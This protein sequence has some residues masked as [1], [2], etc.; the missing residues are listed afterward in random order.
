MNKKG[1]SNLAE[2][3]LV[4]SAIIVLA[5]IIVWGTEKLGPFGYDVVVMECHEKVYK[6]ECG[7]EKCLYTN[8][9]SYH[10]GI[11]HA[12]ETNYLRC[13]LGEK[14]WVTHE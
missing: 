1:L 3:I 9:Y 2:T 5:L 11:R 12:A 10:D 7:L 4:A 8:S 6:E 13:Q 14:E